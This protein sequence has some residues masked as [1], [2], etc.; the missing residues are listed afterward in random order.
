MGEG[1]LHPFAA[2]PPGERVL[3]LP[4]CL[5]PSQT[6]PGRPSREGFQCPVGCE[7]ACPIRTLREEAVRL[8]YKEVC[9][10]PGGA[11]A[12]RFVREVKPRAVIAV[13]C[14]KELQEGEEAVAG[15]G[16]SRP[17]ITVVPLSRDG[18]V[19]TEV[20]LDQALALLRVGTDVG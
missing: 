4:H 16:P 15:L 9:I 19:D 12:L 1:A 5:R 18:C 3:L 14:A 8:G 11:L 20:N 6:C 10:A 7:E 13:A 2:I 17:L